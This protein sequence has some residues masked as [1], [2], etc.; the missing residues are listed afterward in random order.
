[1]Q[2]STCWALII[3][4]ALKWNTELAGGIVCEVSV[5]LNLADMVMESLESWF[6]SN[7][8]HV[9]YNILYGKCYISKI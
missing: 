7:E 6:D 8:H 3:Q 1:M 9:I 2:H 4:W 5:A